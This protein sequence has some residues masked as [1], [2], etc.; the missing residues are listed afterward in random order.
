MRELVANDYFLMIFAAKWTILLSLI[1]FFGG[2]VLGG[3]LAFGRISQMASLRALS[4][5]YI[6]VIQGTPLLIQLFIWYFGLSVVGTNLPSIVAASIALTLNASAFFAEIWRGCLQSI[7]KAQR[8]AAASLALTRFQVNRTVI[9]PQAVRIALAPT[10]GF[11][12]QI[13][14]NTSL[15]A[16][17]GFV[18]LM[19]QGQLINNVTF[20]PL[21]I[22]LT[23]AALYFILCFPLSTLSRYFERKF[24]A[25]RSAD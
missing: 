4:R 15:T 11:M 17:V 20:E 6:Q 9:V 24:D 21:P 10:A 13:I 19:R 18:E 16:L 7:P 23:A 22:Y 25:S 5:I 12:V 2:G 14:K 8:E 3:I 1:A